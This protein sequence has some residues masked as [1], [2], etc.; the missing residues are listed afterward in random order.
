VPAHKVVGIYSLQIYLVLTVKNGFYVV[1][2]TTCLK[3]D[4]FSTSFTKTSY[5]GLI[6]GIKNDCLQFYL[7]L[8]TM[9]LSHWIFEVPSVE[10]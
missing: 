9:C 3:R 2:L 8:K 10:H 7:T 4:I 6:K 1:F 5:L